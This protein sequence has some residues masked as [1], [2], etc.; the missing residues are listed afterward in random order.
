MGDH[1]TTR[2][3]RSPEVVVGNAEEQIR[4]LLA[5]YAMSLNADDAARI[6]QLYTE[7]DF[8]MPGSLPLRVAWTAGR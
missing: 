7:D 2:V 8:F 1:S 5:A 3:E 6:E 4:T